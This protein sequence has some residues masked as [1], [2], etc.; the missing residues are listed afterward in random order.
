MYSCTDLDLFWIASIYLVVT[1]EVACF[2]L[3]PF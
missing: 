3:F 1:L 2:V